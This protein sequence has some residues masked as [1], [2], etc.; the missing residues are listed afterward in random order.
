M[1]DFIQQAVEYIRDLPSVVK[2][3]ALIFSVALE[4][5][6]PIFPG[7]TIVLLAG[8]L[9]AY[10]ALLLL[11]ISLAIFIG[12]LLG[13]SI[14]YAIGRHI[15]RYHGSFRLLQTLVKSQGYRHFAQWYSKWG[16]WFLIFNRFF[17]GIRALFFV[18]AGME[19]ISIAKVLFLGGLSALLYN[20]CLVALG[21]FLGFNAELILRF[22]YQ[23][24]ALAMTLLTGAF[25]LLIFFFWRATRK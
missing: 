17:P 10:D 25:L 24:T 22:F 2:L 14:A 3:I 15:Y 5:I 16:M 4:Y 13:S 21:Y 6:F 19:R 9:K 23:Y 11:D 1:Q 8:F 20:A 12:T 7:D 18:A